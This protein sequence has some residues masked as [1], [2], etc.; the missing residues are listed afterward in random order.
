MLRG[1]A[2]HFDA[3]IGILLRLVTLWSVGFWMY[4]QQY[5]QLLFCAHYTEG[6]RVLQGYNVWVSVSRGQP[7]AAAGRGSYTYMRRRKM[8]KTT[9]ARSTRRS[10]TNFE[11]LAIQF[12]RV[13]KST[14][15]R[16]NL[17]DFSGIP[18]GFV[19]EPP[20]MS[21]HSCNTNYIYNGFRTHEHHLATF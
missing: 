21:D 16:T 17:Y 15:A 2:A 9:N 3:V 11:R 20:D 6:A 10:T 12:H 5:F 18:Q 1:C 7:W 13:P 4:L 8:Y 14:N 19:L